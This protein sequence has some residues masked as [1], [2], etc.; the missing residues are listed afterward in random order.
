MPN[1]RFKKIFDASDKV[2]SG[3]TVEA[4]HVSQ[5]Y[6]A[7]NFVASTV[8]YDIDIGGD[9]ITAGEVKHTDL[10]TSGDVE[11][12][13]VNSTGVLSSVAASTSGT[14]GANG[15]SGTDGV[16]GVNGNDGVNGD[17]GLPGTSG[18][19]GTDGTSGTS[20]ES[21]LVENGANNR[22]VT[23]IDTDEVRGET[24]LTYEDGTGLVI[25]PTDGQPALT[26]IGNKGGAY[27]SGNNITRIIAQANAGGS[28][29][30][31]V[32]YLRW[33]AVGSGNPTPS[34][35]EIWTNNGTN[36]SEKLR[37][38]GSGELVLPF[39]D[40]DNTNFVLPGMDASATSEGNEPDTYFLGIDDGGVVRK[41]Q[42]GRNVTQ[43]YDFS[44]L[45]IGSNTI[46]EMSQ[47][48][49]TFYEGSFRN[50]SGAD[51]TAIIRINDNIT[52][53]LSVNDELY[54]GVK[55][56]SNTSS[57]TFIKYRYKYGGNTYDSHA[58]PLAEKLLNNEMFWATFR[59]VKRDNSNYGLILIN[60]SH[61]TA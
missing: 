25:R 20:G 59:Y 15:T 33:D 34:N 60:D 1:E 35:F 31:N 8:A 32:G 56:F 36:I 13:T 28:G 18:T 38:S 42:G 52:G 24:N 58:I 30:E 45:D 51:Q 50:N 53:S 48:Y 12:V 57:G 43:K 47:S 5:S 23:A 4:P 17:A 21:I 37:V 55:A 41:I 46:F 10:A 7:F 11:F 27:S 22:V 9:L 29:L 14:D 19:D 44:I 54:F 49:A 3:F 16:D 26:L 2:A 39:Y 61:W 40:A 6:D